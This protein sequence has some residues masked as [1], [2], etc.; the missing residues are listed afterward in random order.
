MAAHAEVPTPY[1]DDVEILADLGYLPVPIHAGAKNPIVAGWRTLTPAQAIAL[2]RVHPH[3]SIG[4][5]CDNV[6]TVDCDVFDAEIASLLEAWLIK[7]VVKDRDAL[8]RIG[9][10]PKFAMLFAATGSHCKHKSSVYLDPEDPNPKTQL[11]ACETLGEGQQVVVGGIHPTTGKPYSWPNGGPVSRQVATY[12]LPTLT[13]AQ[14]EAFYDYYDE[15]VARRRPRWVLKQSR[16]GAEPHQG[17]DLEA[18]YPVA[19]LT[20][21]MAREALSYYHNDDLHY[22]D[23]LGVGMA[24]HQQGKG[25][26]DWF[27]VWNEWSAQSAKDAGEHANWKR[28][29]TFNADR[30]GGLTMRSLLWEAEQNGW[31]RPGSVEGARVEQEEEEMFENLD[32]QVSGAPDSRATKFFPELTFP[33]EWGD[34]APP[35]QKWAWDQ[36]VPMGEATLLYALGGTGKTRLVQQLATA[37]A[38]GAPFLG[39]GVAKGTVIMLLCE[40]D[41]DQVIRRQDAIERNGG[42]TRQEIG[43]NVVMLPRKGKNNLLMVFDRHGNPRRT[44]V[45]NTLAKLCLLYKDTL[46]M[47]FIDTLSDVFGGN[48]MDRGHS[49]QMIQQACVSIAQQCHCAVLLAAHPSLNSVTAGRGTSGST[50]WEGA[51]RSRLYMHHDE[52]RDGL[53][54]LDQPKTNLGVKQDQKML[55]MVDG[56]LV[57]VA[58]EEEIEST[59]EVECRSDLLRILYHLDSRGET[60]TDATNSGRCYWKKALQVQR[61]LSPAGTQW[62]RQDYELAM[63]QLVQRGVVDMVRERTDREAR[64]V[65]LMATPGGAEDDE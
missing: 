37:I 21:A 29:E 2:A 5:R 49:R 61:V 32:Q 43:E 10:A 16:T 39:N 45:W 50:G 4:I 18:P 40:D 13:D 14:R 48:E 63:E 47:L 12:E 58:G 17:D 15:V 26:V 41:R 52:E 7:N 25:D 31:T 59:R 57:E 22:D 56:Y 9:Q 11:R 35:P 27:Q 6:R 28:W 19:G 20:P 1:A 24:L 46:S 44:E 42:P 33:G 30:P 51:V 3:A 53:I 64:T 54:L 8:I 36:L 34:Y 60:V 55:R 23:W 62:K 65:M 38:T